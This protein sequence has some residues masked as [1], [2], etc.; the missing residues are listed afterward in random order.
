MA[1]A[2]IFH[3]ACPLRGVYSFLKSI[4]CSSHLVWQNFQPFSFSFRKL[5][6]NYGPQLGRYCPPPNSSSD[7]A[8]SLTLLVR[9]CL[10]GLL[11]SSLCVCQCDPS[12]PEW[13]LMPIW[14]ETL[15]HPPLWQF[16]KS[17]GSCSKCIPCW[18]LPFSLAKSSLV[19]MNRWHQFSEGSLLQRKKGKPGSLMWENAG[20]LPKCCQ[21]MWPL[22]LQHVPIMWPNA[23][24]T[25]SFLTS[26]WKR[27]WF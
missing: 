16:H 15:F 24:I 1:R 7:I 11:N 2:G 8:Y 22:K 26:L 3:K 4:F 18:R 21:W 10:A 14:Q 13:N 5:S 9:K 25:F 17:L 19:K 20:I 12:H 6:L 27:D 23:D